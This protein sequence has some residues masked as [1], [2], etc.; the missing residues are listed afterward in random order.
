MQPKRNVEN[1][2]I[3]ALKDKF[4]SLAQDNVV[5]PLG[6][7]ARHIAADEVGRPSARS[8]LASNTPGIK[9]RHQ[10]RFPE[11]QCGR[12]WRRAEAVATAVAVRV[13]AEL[14]LAVAEE[15]GWV[16]LG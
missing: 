4:A 7:D 11:P 16:V 9:R 10:R 3:L 12:R 1:T 13:A 5:V 14:A 8:L 2:G 15:A 6:A